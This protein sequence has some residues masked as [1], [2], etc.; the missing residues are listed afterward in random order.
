MRVRRILDDVRR[1]AI[2]FLL[3]ATNSFSQPFESWVW[4]I[5]ALLAPLTTCA[6]VGV[7][8]QAD[9]EFTP[10][11]QAAIALGIVLDALRNMGHDP[12]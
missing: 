3:I 1:A 5:S 10:V 4:P 2:L 12:V 11:W 7:V 6:L 9:C 8:L